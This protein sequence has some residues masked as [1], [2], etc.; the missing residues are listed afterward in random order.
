MGFQSQPIQEKELQSIKTAE[1]MLQTIRTILP[2]GRRGLAWP[3]EGLEGV[4]EDS[5]S[6]WFLASD[7]ALCHCWQTTTA[8]VTGGWSIVGSAMLSLVMHACPLHR[9]YS[10]FMPVLVT[11][12]MLSVKAA[13]THFDPNV[14]A[15]NLPTKLLDE[16][17]SKLR[18]E[19]DRTLSFLTL[20]QLGT[21]NSRPFSLQGG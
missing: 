16:A 19:V 6:I 8:K 5:G 3:L 13:E 21:W 20:F 12:L 1:P 2:R 9:S 4:A 14:R 7:C 11:A 15:R 10:K 18:Q 17:S